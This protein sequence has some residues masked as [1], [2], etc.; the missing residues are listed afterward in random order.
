MAGKLSRL[1]NSFKITCSDCVNTFREASKV[2]KGESEKISKSEPLIITREK[3]PAST[4]LLDHGPN[5]VP[6]K[7]KTNTEFI[8][9]EGLKP[10]SESGDYQ[11][12]ICQFAKRPFTRRIF[13]KNERRNSYKYFHPGT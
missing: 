11:I 2:A 1:F 9:A 8:V 7:K 6:P 10:N 13:R 4:Q 12:P 5:I 3:P